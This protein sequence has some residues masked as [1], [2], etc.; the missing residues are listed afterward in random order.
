[1]KYYH[2]GA[3]D[4]PIIAETDVLVAGAGPAGIGAALSAARCGA[5]VM[6]IEKYG[7]LGG[8]GTAAAVAIRNNT[9]LRDVNIREVQQILLD[10]GTEL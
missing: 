7:Y 2:E 6:L 10:N 8:G 4:I 3:R 5:K 9:E 1:M